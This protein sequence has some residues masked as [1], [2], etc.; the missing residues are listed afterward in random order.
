M[1]LVIAAMLL[2][3]GGYMV[4]Q[5]R[6]SIVAFFVGLYGLTGMIWGPQLLRTIFF[7]F[8]LFAFCVPLGNSA[9]YITFPMRMLVTHLSVG[10]SHE[11]LGIDVI[12]DGS[13]I[14][15]AD[16]SFQYDVAPACSG[17]R[18]L[19]TLLALTTIFG[20][21]SFKTTWKRI[22]M[23]LLAGPLAVLGNTI[24]ITGVIVTG[25][26]FGHDAGA[27][28]EQKLGFVTFAVA[29]VA[30]LA[31]GHWLREER[32]PA[33]EKSTGAPRGEPEAEAVSTESK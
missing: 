26:A 31:I 4:Q 6:V 32:G 29:L 22:F 9:E 33:V 17:I 10:F 19:I 5:T 18:S 8:F 1:G 16:G 2:H 25:E 23:V 11:I 13:R 3:L 28:I 15:A 20:F 27:W 14:F 12:R 7:P 30:V 24:R 21:L